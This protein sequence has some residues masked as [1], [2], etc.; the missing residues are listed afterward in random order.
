[1]F[2]A[3]E[4]QRCSFRPH[5]TYSIW[6]VSHAHCRVER[7][8]MSTIESSDGR[9]ASRSFLVFPVSGSFD[10]GIVTQTC[11]SLLSANGI[12]A[13][14]LSTITPQFTYPA[15]TT[16]YSAPPFCANRWL[17][18]D[19]NVATIYS[20]ASGDD[21]YTSCQPAETAP[22]Y[23]P[24]MCPS[25]HTVASITELSASGSS[26]AEINRVWRGLCCRR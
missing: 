26:T 16:A 5:L 12:I 8:A 1:V 7:V 25:G 23:S 17:L 24:G 9:V 22:T 20:Q 18:Q 4:N 10:G 2:F 13:C 21:F 14:R 19:P 15:L 11:S 3:L 6:L